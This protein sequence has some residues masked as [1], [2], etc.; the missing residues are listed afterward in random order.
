[1]EHI[2]TGRKKRRYRLQNLKDL[3][4]KLDVA[5]GQPRSSETRYGE[6]MSVIRIAQRLRDAGMGF[7]IVNLVP[8]PTAVLRRDRVISRLAY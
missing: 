7:E 4:Q 5:L 8:T 1:M 2:R 3:T 6:V